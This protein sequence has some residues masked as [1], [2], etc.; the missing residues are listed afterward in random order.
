MSCVSGCRGEGPASRPS[1]GAAY[2]VRPMEGSDGGI[3]FESFGPWCN[4][5]A[6][7]QTRSERQCSRCSKWVDEGWSYGG[8]GMGRLGEVSPGYGAQVILARL[9]VQL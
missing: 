9:V 7:A 4:E 8:I 3:R 6:G 5:G 2:P 1:L